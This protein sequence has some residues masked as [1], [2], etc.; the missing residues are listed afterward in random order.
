MNRKAFS[1]I[2]LFT[3]SICLSTGY[4][5]AVLKIDTRNILDF[6]VN[7]IVLKDRLDTEAKLWKTLKVKEITTQYQS[8]RQE[9]RAISLVNTEG[10]IYDRKVYDE[11]NFLITTFKVNYENNSHEPLYIEFEGNGNYEAHSLH[12][13][14]GKLDYIK[15]DFDIPEQDVVQFYYGSGKKSNQVEKIVLLRPNEPAL[16]TIFLYDNFGRLSIVQNEIGKTEYAFE[17]SEN[18]VVMNYRFIV[19]DV[20]EYTN[21]IF[22]KHT[23][24]NREKGII[25]SEEY[26]FGEN[27]LRNEGTSLNKDGIT[28]NIKINWK[29]YE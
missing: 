17:Y 10:Y 7:N 11:D 4:S 9:F 12:Y 1:F 16:T 15:T 20:F 23:Q 18:K 6:I 24:T 28:T 25:S 3:F 13:K 27:G 8:E 19:E 2:L 5:Q 29:Y 22:R 14:N 21:S 26:T